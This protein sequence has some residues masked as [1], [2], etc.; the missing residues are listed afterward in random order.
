MS[1]VETI[2]MS[3]STAE[4]QEFYD[5]TEF[6]G[7]LEA[8]LFRAHT[9]SSPLHL[10]LLDTTNFP[11]GQISKLLSPGDVVGDLGERL[12][13]IIFPD[14]TEEAVVKKS[15]EVIKIAGN[16]IYCITKQQVHDTPI[17]LL[18]RARM[19]LKEAINTNKPIM[20]S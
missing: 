13:G 17:S 11:E 12:Y 16:G 8:E 19:T 9:F 14:I 6:L 3:E 10:T 5:Q 4:R 15:Q 7:I 2:T 18:H 20:S 1:Y